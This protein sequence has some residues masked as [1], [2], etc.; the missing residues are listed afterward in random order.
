M[1]HILYANF[2]VKNL[3]LVLLNVGNVCYSFFKNYFWLC[4]VF[5]AVQAF[6]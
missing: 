2:S 6:L 5:V 3:P 4:W 1:S